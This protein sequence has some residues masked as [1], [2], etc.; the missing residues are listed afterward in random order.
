MVKCILLRFGHCTRCS[1]V[2]FFCCSHTHSRL[3]LIVQS[4]RILCSP[5]FQHTTFQCRV[6]F[7]FMVT[8]GVFFL[9]G[10]IIVWLFPSLAEANALTFRPNFSNQLNPSIEQTTRAGFISP[11]YIDSA[12]KYTV[13]ANIKITLARHGGRVYDVC[14]CVYMQL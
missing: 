3:A 4:V 14:V 1:G 13:C 8:Y 10:S 11:V 7:C 6:F 12:R 9:L 2:F 5:I